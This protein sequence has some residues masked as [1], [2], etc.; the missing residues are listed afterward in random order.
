VGSADEDEDDDDVEESTQGRAKDD[1]KVIFLFTHERDHKWTLSNYILLIALFLTTLC[2]YQTGLQS[3]IATVGARCG[4]GGD[5]VAKGK[6]AQPGV[7]GTLQ[8]FNRLLETAEK[9]FRSMPLVT[10]SQ[11]LSSSKCR[12][13]IF[14][15]SS[16]DS[17]GS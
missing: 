17:D 16:S 6:D 9:S 14:D 1:L 15:V 10:L 2:L 7:L 11:E 4:R 5:G 8:E 12:G 3:L 13:Y